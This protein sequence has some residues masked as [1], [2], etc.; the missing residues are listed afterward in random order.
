MLFITHDLHLARKIADRA[1][2]LKGAIAA[3][4]GRIRNFRHRKSGLCSPGHVLRG[5]AS[6]CHSRA[7]G[8]H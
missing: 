5:L 1:Y 6:P 3:Q 4:G 8:N 7:C 2:V